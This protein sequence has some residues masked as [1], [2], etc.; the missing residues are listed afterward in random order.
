[1]KSPVDISL[2]LYQDLTNQI[3]VAMNLSPLGAQMLA[4]LILDIDDHGYSFEELVQLFNA[5][6]SSIS[7][8]LQVLTKLELVEVTHHIDCRKRFFKLNRRNHLSLRLKKVQSFMMSEL[9]IVDQ[10]MD[11]V[12]ARESD[13]SI[14]LKR[15]DVY[16]DYLQTTIGQLN[17]TLD[18]LADLSI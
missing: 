8:N 9:N 11:Y 15:L 4:Y 6:K 17:K 5:S 10:Y 16:K 14:A 18:A 13:H 12:A 1:M 7:H 2:P 3:Q